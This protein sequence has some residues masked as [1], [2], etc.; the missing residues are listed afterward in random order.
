MGKGFAVVAANE[1]T[2]LIAD[3][4]MVTE[5]IAE[6]FAKTVEEIS[7]VSTVINTT[8]HNAR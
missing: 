4:R 3:Q 6:Q 7:N 8:I 2:L 5:K 1:L